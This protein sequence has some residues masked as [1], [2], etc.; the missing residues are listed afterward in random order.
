MPSDAPPPLGRVT[1]S[2]C[3]WAGMPHCGA[4][5]HTLHSV[6]A[7]RTRERGETERRDAWGRGTPSV[8]V[9]LQAAC[10][11]LR[12]SPYGGHGA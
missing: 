7:V 10:I 4:R 5:L 6:S 1:T 9:Q 12:E 2:T 3:S 8:P 11:A